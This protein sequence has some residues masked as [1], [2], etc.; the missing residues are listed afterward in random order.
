MHRTNYFH[1]LL[2]AFALLTTIGCGEP[3]FDRSSDV[4][5]IDVLVGDL[6]DATRSTATFQALFAANAAPADAERSK[7]AK[8]TYRLAE[9]PAIDGEQA[10]L[11]VAVRD[12]NDAEIAV[13]DWK[14]T[15]VEN[16]WRLS[17]APLPK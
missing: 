10:A 7:Y 1:A 6:S 4:G 12:D 5:Q 15:K 8:Y 2:V 3:E 16:A 17:A 9:E 11:R 14:A 13:A